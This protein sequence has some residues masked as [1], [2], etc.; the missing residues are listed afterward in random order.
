MRQKQNLNI[1]WHCCGR[2]NKKKVV[3]PQNQKT[4]VGDEKISRTLVK[5][6][7]KAEKRVLPE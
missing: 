7:F 1:V 5:T 6:L 2:S 4:I 3:E